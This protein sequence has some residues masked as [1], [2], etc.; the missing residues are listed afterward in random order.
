MNSRRD[1]LKIT[2]LGGTALI[3]GVGSQTKNAFR[4]N[5][6][7]Q[8]DRDGDV[9]LTVGKSEMGQ[10]VRTSLPMILADELGA[11]W[12][13]VRIVQAS[14]GPD[15]KSLN[16]G[17][18]WSIGG[19]WKPLRT[20]GAAAREMLIA[21]AAKR[22]ATERTNL[23]TENGFVVDG[24]RR[25][26]FQDLID[27]AA[28][29]EVPKN[30]PLKPASE[31]R[32]IG[33]RIS[34]IDGCDIVTGKAK[35]GIDA[36]VPGM[37]FASIARPPAVGGTVKHFDASKS[38]NVRGVREVVSISSG[39]AV[40]GDDTWAALK[41]R[42]FLDVTFDD[43]PNADFDSERFMETLIDASKRDGVVMSHK[44]DVAHASPAKMIEATYVYPFYAHAPVETMN[45]VAHARPNSCEIW[46]PT[47]SPPRVQKLVGRKLGISPDNV[48]VHVTLVGGGFGRRLSADYAV[49]AAELSRAIGR[50]VQVLWTRPDDMQHGHLQHASV[51]SLRGGIDADGKLVSWS[52]KK[53][54]NPIMT[55]DD[56][57]T[58]AE[59]A[60]LAAA[61]R[62]SAWGVPDIPYAIPNIETSY[63]RVDSPIRYGPWRAVYAPSSVFARESFFDELAHAAGRD[64]LQL[65][66]DLTNGRLRRVLEALRERSNWNGR[67]Q[68]VACNIYD[69]ETT[70]AYV[71]EV[72][73][74]AKRVFKVDRVVCVVDCGQVINPIGVEQQV[75]GG[76]IWALAQLRSQIT[77]RKGRV[78]QST[79]RDYPVPRI[80]DAPV[81]ETH[82]LPT[83]NAGP[84]GMGE[85]PVPPLVPAVFNAYFAASG[86]RVRRLPIAPSS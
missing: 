35:Y 56:P 80:D 38:K 58:A 22:W 32:I 5:A 50:P 3:L 52:H 1:F 66:L 4:P 21:A 28:K 6:W 42:S 49:E 43:G 85:P 29:I 9:T 16:T 48:K 15:F 12:S 30:P 39:V 62:D 71:A 34:R 40:V 23:R 84:T 74:D 18:S 8:I 10:G 51:H 61:Y 27:D 69:G 25:I 59:M 19:S 57:P 82:I 33:K 55:I 72:S 13:R 45:C 79:Y 81:I 86:V 64:P 17:G 60:D 75:E 11:D 63:V 68:G 26:A 83:E 2:A 44:G 47:Q 24:A 46:A 77:I 76:V 67:A 78:E 70:I 7:L 53:I 14:T 37:L 36:R 41:G 54:S 73:L 20:V 31:F 65:R